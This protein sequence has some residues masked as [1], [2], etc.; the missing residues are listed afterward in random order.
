MEDKSLYNSQQSQGI[1]ETL[2]NYIDSMVEEIVL[3]GKP[4]DAQ[5]KYLRKFSEKEGLNYDKLEEDINTFLEIL[6]SLETAFNKPQVKLAEEKGRECYISEG[7]IKKLVTH[8][9]QPK[10]PGGNVKTQGYQETK[11]N[12]G[13]FKV[14]WLN[15]I[16]FLSCIFFLISIYAFILLAGFEAVG[17]AMVV[18]GLYLQRRTEDRNPKA[19]RWLFIG[20][21]VIFLI[22]LTDGGFYIGIIYLIIS[23]ITHFLYRK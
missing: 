8:S 2:Q 15:V 5:K 19:I 13:S 9:S 14:I 23:I 17:C 12:K 1:S 11:Q 3:E 4:F 16:L 21:F 6:E 7:T 20:S 22:G 18:Y 10:Q